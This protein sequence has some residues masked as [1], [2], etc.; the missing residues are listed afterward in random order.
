MTATF[1]PLQDGEEGVDDKLEVL[2][3]QVH[4]SF[5]HDGEISSQAFRP[6]PKDAGKLSVRRQAFG[7]ERAY[8][9]HLRLGYLT[10]GTWGVGVGEVEEAAARTVDDSALPDR[11]ESHAYVDYRHLSRRQVET[12][13][14][15][16]KSAAGARGKAYP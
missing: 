1:V 11:P 16:L 3:R 8:H 2:W 4:P 10:A 14:K 5:V 9:D 6:T 15:R 12:A 7:A 13:A